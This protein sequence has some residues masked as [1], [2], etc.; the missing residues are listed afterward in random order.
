[1][2]EKKGNFRDMEAPSSLTVIIQ[3]AAGG[4]GADCTPG[5]RISLQG[6]SG[7]TQQGK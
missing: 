1:M 3:T 4:N 2:A 7:L 5:T 6:P